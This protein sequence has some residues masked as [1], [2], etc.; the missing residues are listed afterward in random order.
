MNYQEL[1][2]AIKIIY[3]DFFRE[4]GI[5][6]TT[7]IVHGTNYRFTGFPYIGRNYLSAPLRL[8]FIPLDVGYDECMQSNSYH[9]LEDR[10]SIFPDGDLDFNPHIAGMYSTALYILKDKMGWVDAW[11][12]LWSKR[13]S[14]KMRKAIHNSYDILPKDL[15]SYLAYDNRFRFVT[16]GRTRR[17]GGKDRVYLQPEIEGQLL[18]DEI[19]LLNPDYII[20]QGRYGLWNCHLDELKRKYQVI[21]S[22]HPSCWQRGAD[23]L[24]YI[25]ESLAPQIS[26]PKC[27]S[28][29]I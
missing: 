26:L 16:L 23:K 18:L 21:E 6:R 1:Q 2:I 27:I 3:V 13:D 25:V 11:K 17:T 10:E 24:Q 8:F 14:F 4:M 28:K 15:M 29:T 20:F 9:S 7:G 5:D 12:T 19:S 22:Y